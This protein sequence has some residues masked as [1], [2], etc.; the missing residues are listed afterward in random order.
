[1]I[2]AEQ[3]LTRAL[4]YGGSLSVLMMDVDHFKNINDTYG[5]K[6]GTTYCAGSLS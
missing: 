5:H 2:L 6:T 4:R 1:M 3:E